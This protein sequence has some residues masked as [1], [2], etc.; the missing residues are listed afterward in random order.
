MSSN[1]NACLCCKHYDAPMS[2]CDLKWSEE[3][4]AFTMHRDMFTYAHE[5][6]SKF[7]KKDGD[8]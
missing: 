2:E 7:E 3:S 5:Y 8:E 1:D 6:C 4:D